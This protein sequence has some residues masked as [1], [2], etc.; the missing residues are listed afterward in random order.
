MKRTLTY[1]IFGIL[2]PLF[3]SCIFDEV[4]ET[5]NVSNDLTV[6]FTL[7][8]DSQPVSRSVSAIDYDTDFENRIDMSSLLVFAYD[9]NGA[10]IEQ[11]PILYRSENGAEVME[12]VCGLQ[13][14]YNNRTVKLVVF[15]KL[16]SQ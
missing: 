5:E 10:F 4:I 8:V 2:L 12:L 16:L 1:L 14:P 11:L 9:A 15:Q 7:K 13:N 6:T 3:S